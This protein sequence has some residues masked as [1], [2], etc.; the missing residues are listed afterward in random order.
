MIIGNFLL[1]DCFSLSLIL[2]DKNSSLISAGQNTGFFDIVIGNPPYGADIDKF[3]KI[4]EKIYP[5]TS[6]GFKDIYK[7]FFDMSLTLLN[8]CGF[9]CFITPNTFLRQPRYSDLRR[10]LL[11]KNITQIID[12]GEHVFDN[13]VVPTA[14]SMI[15]MKKLKNILFADLTKYDNPKIEIQNICFKVIEKQIFEKTPNN[16]FVISTR[17]KLLNE[18]L[19]DDILIMKDAG[20]NY[21]R[22]NVGL[23]DKGNTDLNKRLFY[24]GKKEKNN[25]I[26]YYKGVDI[27]RYFM[28]K[29]TSRF[30][31]LN[32][33]LNE[34]ERVI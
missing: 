18:Y 26:E 15:S 9:L 7:Y 27:N 1:L 14:I 17:E 31:R 13:V 3:T 2:Q 28:A 21:Q 10:L 29:K 22:I 4:F 12:L 25:D 11:E 24:E 23:N 32:I 34:N 33:K 5:K 20:I 19:L 16:L 8:K 6:H 30:V